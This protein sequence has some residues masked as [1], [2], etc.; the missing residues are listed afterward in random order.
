M[1]PLLEDDLMMWIDHQRS[2]N[3]RVSRKMV[4]LKGKE[5][6][7]TGNYQTIEEEDEL[8]AQ[9]QGAQ[10]TVAFSASRG[11]LQKFLARHGITLR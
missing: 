2:Q 8:A 5:M 4:M 9:D 6:Y 3:L 11:W 7:T 1:L 10:Q